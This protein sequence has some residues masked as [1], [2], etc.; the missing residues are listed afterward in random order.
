MKQY[1]DLVKYVLENGEDVN[2]RTGVGTRSIFGYQMR[3]DLSAGFPA[4]T[5]KKLAWKAVVGELLWFLE[6]STDERRLAELT[7]G[8]HRTELVGRGTIWTANADAQG[9]ALGYQ[10][11]DFYKGLGPVYGFQWRNFDAF[12]H[13]I[14]TDQISWL[15]NEIRTNP[16]SRRLILSAWNPNQLHEMALPP[17]HYAFQL[18]VHNGKLSGMLT[19][20][21]NDVFLGA[22]FNIASYALLIHIFARE[23][24]LVAGELIYSIGDA[25]I[26]LNHVDQVKEQ[27]LRSEY[28]LPKLKID[29]DFDLLHGLENQFKI[30][31]VNKFHLENYLHHPTIKGKMAV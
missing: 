7:Y 30:D 20:R 2:D 27:L 31:T 19:M 18:R 15:I 25:H 11:H 17:C 26:Y 1:H 3:F 22:P 23:T 14:G 8:K 28:P 6:G 29:E 5:T 12:G 4:V 9:K 16:D 24:C 10:H 21:S 13:N